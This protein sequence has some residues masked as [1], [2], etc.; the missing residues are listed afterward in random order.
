MPIVK[1]LKSQ[2]YYKSF[3]A[4]KPRGITRI[5]ILTVVEGGQYVVEVCFGIVM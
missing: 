2:I 4:R 3:R 5:V 1:R